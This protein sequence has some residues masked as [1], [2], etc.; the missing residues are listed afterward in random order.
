MDTHLSGLLRFC[1]G[2]IASLTRSFDVQAAQLPF[3]EVYG[4]RGTLSGP[5]PNTFGGPVR[6]CPAD[7]A[8]FSDRPLEFPFTENSR[9]LGLSDMADAIRTA[10]APRAGGGIALHVLKTMHGILESVARGVTV[11]IDSRPERPLPMPP[12]SRMA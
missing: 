9:G 10:R 6:V 5:D 11:Q 8:E 2:A 1:S 4:A 7:S 12:C 3:I